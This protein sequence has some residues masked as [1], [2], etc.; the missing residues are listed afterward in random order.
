M[1]HLFRRSV[2]PGKSSRKPKDNPNSQKELSEDNT[3]SA[4]KL[5]LGDESSSQISS[6]ESFN[7]PTGYHFQDVDIL[8]RV[9]LAPP[10]CKECLK[11]T[12]QLFE[13]VSGCGLARTL[14]LQYTNNQRE[15]Y[16]RESPFLWC[17]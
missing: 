9:I 5:P 17:E 6:K 4:K 11:G 2:A 12:L 7:R 1:D 8:R 10:V 13:K 14:V 3:P 16:T 15:N